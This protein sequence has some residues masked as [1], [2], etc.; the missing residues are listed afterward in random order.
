LA[1]R[2]AGAEGSRLGIEGALDQLVKILR[3]R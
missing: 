2:L 3:R 1:R